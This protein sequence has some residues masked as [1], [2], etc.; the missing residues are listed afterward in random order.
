MPCG[1]KTIGSK[2]FYSQSPYVTEDLVLPSSIEYIQKYAF[3]G[4]AKNISFEAGSELLKLDDAIGEAYGREYNLDLSNCLHLKYV[5]ATDYTVSCILPIGV[6][7]MQLACTVVNA[8]KVVRSLDDDN[9]LVI[10][11]DIIAI[12]SVCLDGIESIQCSENQVFR[13]DQGCL[14]FTSEDSTSLIAAEV[15][16][17][18]VTVGQSM[19]AT[20][21]SEGAFSGTD[22]HELRIEAPVKVSD[23]AVL[24]ADSLAVVYLQMQ[25][26]E[27]LSISERSFETSNLDIIF[28]ISSGFP[29]QFIPYLELY[30]PVFVGYVFMDNNIYLPGEAGDV[31]IS[32]MT[33]DTGE[34]FCATPTFSG[35]YTIYDVD[36][37][38]S[39]SQYSLSEGSIVISSITGDVFV[40]ITV[41]DR[42][43]GTIPVIFNGNG[44]YCDGKDMVLLY[45]PSGQTIVDSEIPLFVKDGADFSDEYGWCVSISPKESYDFSAPVSEPIQ[46]YADWTDRDLKI[47][48]ETGPGAV[49]CNGQ[50]VTEISTQAGSSVTLVFTPYPGYEVTN[51][52][53]EKSGQLYELS[54]DQP[55][56]IENIDSD[57]EIRFEYVYYS[58]SSGLNSVVNRGLPEGDDLLRLVR[59][60]E[61]G[62][63]VITSGMVWSGTD[64]VPLIVGNS[65]YF[66]AGNYIYAAE[67]DTGYI[68]AKAESREAADFY[69]ELGYGNG[70]IVDY[71]TGQCFDLSLNPIF[72]IPT[73]VTGVEYYSGYFYTSGDS[74]Y[75]FTSDD[76]VPDT[77]D[78]MKDLVLVTEIYG[79]YSDYGFAHSVFVDDYMYRIYASGISRGIIG[80]NLTTGESQTCAMPGIN[81]MYLDDGWI[82]YSD[83]TLFLT[84]YSEGLFGA[85]A[86]SRDDTMAYVDVN[87]L[88]FGE[89]QYLT[90]TG[91]K[92]AVSEFVVD[93]NRGYVLVG[94]QLQAY[95][96]ADAQN[97]SCSKSLTLMSSMGAGFSHGSIVVDDSYATADNGNLAY[98]YVIPYAG[99]D[100]TMVVLAVTDS[101][102]ESYT[103]KAL[104]RNWNSQAVRSDLDGRMTWYNDSGHIFTYTVPEKNVYFFFLSDGENAKWIEGYGSNPME[105]LSSAYVALSDGVLLGARMDV[106]EEYGDGWSAY[107]LANTKDMDSA[108]Y[109]L[110]YLEWVE[111]NGDLTG[112]QYGDSHYWII[113]KV[114]PDELK[115]KTWY[116][117]YDSSKQYVLMDNIGDRAVVGVKLTS[118]QDKIVYSITIGDV[119][120]GAV[121]ADKDCAVDGETVKLA[122]VPDYGYELNALSV[123][124][125]DKTS[126]V[127]KGVYS[128]ILESDVSIEASFTQKKVE[129]TVTLNLDGGE[130]ASVTAE[131]GWAYDSTAKTWS[132]AFESGSFLSVADP[133]KE[134]D[135]SY[136]Y[137]FSAWDPALPSSVTE[138]K[139]YTATYAETPIYTVTLDLAGGESA[140]VTAESGWAY[141]STAKTWS[142]AF[143][144]GAQFPQIADPVKEADAS[145]SYEFSGWD[146]DLPSTVTGS[147]TYTALYT[148]A[149]LPSA[150]VVQVPSA[151][152]GLVYNGKTQT[153]VPSGEGYAVSNGKAKDAGSYT[154]TLT[155]KDG[156]EWSDGK[157]T[158]KTVKWTISKAVLTARYA[159][160]TIAEGS[161]PAYKV[162]VTGFVNG[163]SAA[164]A[165]G[166]KAP[167]V[168]CPDLSPGSYTLTPSEG[169]A[170]NY[171][172]KYCSGVLVIEALPSAEVGAVFAVD[173]LIYE[174]ASL[175]PATASL[176]GYE[177][178][179]VDVA[180]PASVTFADV[181]FRV[182]AVGEKAF[183]GCIT[184]RSLDLG[185]VEDVGFKAFANCS[186]LRDLA[187]PE[188]VTLIEG[189]AF[190]GCG[191]VSLDIPGDNVVLEQSAFSACTK[192]KDIAFSG[193]GAVIGANAFYKN[194][195]VTTVD[196]S[197]VA[198]VGTKA[199]PYCNGM[200]TLTIPGSLPYVGAYAFYKCAN[201]RTLVVEEGVGKILPSAFSECTA[202]ESVS[203]PSTLTYL[204][205]N[206]F[207]GLRF[208]DQYGGALDATAKDLRGH[209]F[210]GSGKVLRMESEAGD[211]GGFT[212]GGISYT[213]TSAGTV[214]ATG[215]EGAVTAIPSTVDYG[216]RSYA[217]TAI[218]SSALLRCATLASADL[219]NVEFLE[220][221]ALGNCTGITEIAF[222]DCLRG[223]GDYALY[224]LSFY[225]GDQKITATPK[226]L[227]GH[228]FSGSGAALYLVS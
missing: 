191:I 100:I 108:D 2:A 169:S 173:G 203:L 23:G 110:D 95:S 74:V 221:K 3:E 142:K 42:T 34:S 26:F 41:K 227:R 119:S 135:G 22:L 73:T 6:Y 75:R 164:T 92:L 167:K 198:S 35:G 226:S 106:S 44:G 28:V 160:E 69:H 107:A 31:R 104:P 58:P 180:V 33:D 151:A 152:T 150:Q 153:G 123:D 210:S 148:E 13:A 54:V 9:N 79:T 5:K 159:G 208:T 24:S 211:V 21:I 138:S 176:I 156:Y 197:T 136:S 168:S 162:S 206:A 30:G 64:S 213:V 216:G 98:V 93:G 163:E 131:S 90:F 15:S 66:R 178:S 146:K 158:S 166:Y 144:S 195:G 165:S 209:S 12:N 222:G 102:I 184:L 88:E 89:V 86:A 161:A 37:E 228:T 141:D 183:Y 223:I 39:N 50:V 38:T 103:T 113:S 193:S 97:G 11:S 52:V 182:I 116:H 1:V 170:K 72:K 134:A 63:K 220:F 85:V 202:L 122:V 59:V 186:A 175:D 7:E 99:N 127:V 149:P 27:G 65:I 204:G 40:Q 47:T 57:V 70:V 61:L 101:G 196:L 137:A 177:G 87:G 81:S 190:Y 29:E 53:Y 78:E 185:S 124:G 84:S 20:E 172:F 133:V 8:D 25:S 118:A 187:V 219:S 200:T 62:G 129:Y 19:G 215:Y 225:D 67:S 205:D 71:N 60:S 51:W 16:V 55:L 46:L 105:A 174:I 68:Y 49:T 157:T 112:Q 139:T 201:L 120:Y 32:W 212:V 179:P 125:V 4:Y 111:T 154:A 132:K 17:S 18:S 192:M 109:S 115:S 155:L 189:Y 96:I 143:E 128:F 76:E 94:G 147:A 36:V 80:V 130:S 91:N 14:L 171:S 181:G 77:T 188:T 10:G 145:Y 224:G 43:L 48:I 45:I 207:Y 114:S 56:T 218:G 199:F 121:M 126:D 214:T 83:G 217:V 194:N 82:S 140:S 117:L